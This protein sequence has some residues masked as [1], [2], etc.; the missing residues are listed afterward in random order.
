M[1]EH[2]WKACLLM[3]I[4]ICQYMWVKNHLQIWSKFSC[5]HV[6]SCHN[7]LQCVSNVNAPLTHRWHHRT[8][9]VATGGRLWGELWLPTG[10]RR[11]MA[12]C[13]IVITGIIRWWWRPVSAV[14]FRGSKQHEHG[15][16]WRRQVR[17]NSMSRSTG[18]VLGASPQ[19]I[20]L[21]VGLLGWG[22]G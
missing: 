20:R 6:M 10:V 16:C 3:Y 15:P 21:G 5:C 14:R 1:N 4:H 18:V 9:P 2:I 22:Q 13:V 11:G 7:M 8:V 12:L 19:N 17:V